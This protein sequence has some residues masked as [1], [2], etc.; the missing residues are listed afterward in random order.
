MRKLLDLNTWLALIF[1]GHS[2]HQIARHWYLHESLSAGD[3]LFCRQTEMGFLRLLT[4]SRAM[5]A[6]GQ[7]AF[8]NTAAIQFLSEILRNDAIGMIDET[9]STRSLWLA[10]S[11]TE[12]SSPNIWM[13]AWLASLAM[14]H[15]LQLVTLDQGFTAYQAMGLSLHL[16]S[17]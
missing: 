7:S 6:C 16:L 12:M 10:L 5:Q 11:K 13:D 8:S 1:A 15:N 3:L 17:E 14:T 2:Q 9:S 4:Q